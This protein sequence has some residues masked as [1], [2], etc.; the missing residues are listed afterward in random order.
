MRRVHTLLGVPRSD[1]PDGVWHRGDVTASGM[2]AFE[3][4]KTMIAADMFKPDEIDFVLT[5]E[6]RRI[7]M[8]AVD[9]GKEW[10]DQ[11]GINASR[12][13]ELAEVTK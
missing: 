2:L 11:D 10:R 5:D 13:E 8:L 6:L 12:L 7:V 4:S 1:A 9:I 3:A